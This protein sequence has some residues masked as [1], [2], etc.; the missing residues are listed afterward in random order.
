MPMKE[1]LITPLEM[2]I[3]SPR[4]IT[5]GTIVIYSYL[6]YLCSQK[7]DRKTG[8]KNTELKEILK[9]DLNT[10]KKAVSTLK[11]SKY[12][13]ISGSTRNRRIF[14]NDPYEIAKKLK[15]D[16]NKAVQFQK[17]EL[18]K[19][20]MEY[21]EDIPKS[22]RIEDVRL[23]YADNYQKLSIIN[24]MKFEK[25]GDPKEVKNINLPDFK[26]FIKLQINILQEKERIKKR[27]GEYDKQHQESFKEE[28]RKFYIEKNI[29]DIREHSQLSNCPYELQKDFLLWIE[30]ELF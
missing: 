1:F 29:V 9:M 15:E 14:C 30:P 10:I 8:I 24:R 17:M 3:D 19:W 13:E 11:K 20:Y 22:Q 25:T 12:I 6:F 28:L 18:E 2:L 21:I 4:E 16:K 27:A 7:T 23:Y 26:K 5:P